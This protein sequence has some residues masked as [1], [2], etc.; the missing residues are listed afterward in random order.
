MACCVVGCRNRKGREKDVQYHRI[1]STRTPFSVRR[2]AL[3]LQAM[4]RADCPGNLIK[5]ARLCSAHFISGKVSMDENSP[6]FVPSVFLHPSHTQTKRPQAN[7]ERKRL[8]WYAVPSIQPEISTLPEEWPNKKRKRQPSFHDYCLPG[9]IHWQFCEAVSEPREGEPEDG[10]QGPGEQSERSDNQTPRTACGQTP[11]QDCV[12]TPYWTFTTEKHIQTDPKQK[13]KGGQ[14]EEAAEDSKR[15]TAE[16]RIATPPPNRTPHQRKALYEAALSNIAK[17]VSILEELG[18]K[19][20]LFLSVDYNNKLS[21]LG[22]ENC[23]DG[24]ND[25]QIELQYCFLSSCMRN[26]GQLKNDPCEKERREVE[27]IFSRKYREASGTV[28]RSYYKPL[29]EGR[30]WA[31]GMPRGMQL[32]IPVHYDKPDLEA[33]IRQQDRIYFVLPENGGELLNANTESPVKMDMR[34]MTDCSSDEEHSSNEQSSD[35]DD[36]S[37]NSMA[38][39]SGVEVPL[40]RVKEEEESSYTVMWENAGHRS[41]PDRYDTETTQS[42]TRSMHRSVVPLAAPKRGPVETTFPKHCL[43][44]EEETKQGAPEGVCKVEIKEEEQEWERQYSVKW[45]GYEE[46]AWDPESKGTEAATVAFT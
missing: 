11:K 10:E 43:V 41:F 37:E 28:D 46:T 23:L 40:C 17:Q 16:P 25:H 38:G 39:P 24:L 14:R 13:G 44:K 18:S 20:V 29:S 5:N 15:L 45:E 33:I 42:N 3:W 36:A 19:G 32:K 30:L 7:S 21:S 22:T 1:P 34:D 27:Y 8:K 6:D 4:K 2:R 12:Q 9:S 35:I 31:A 26:E